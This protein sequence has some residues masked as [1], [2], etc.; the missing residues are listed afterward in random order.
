LDSLPAQLVQPAMRRSD[1]LVLRERHEPN[2]CFGFAR[3]PRRVD[4]REFYGGIIPSGFSHWV[5]NGESVEVGVYQS[6]DASQTLV[7]TFTS[8]GFEGHVR[9]HDWDRRGPL[10]WMRFR[11]RR[12]GPAT[13][14]ACDEAL[15][16]GSQLKR[17][18][19]R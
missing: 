8:D 5:Q 13:A 15:K 6:P 16:L 2:A 3:S 19:P 14:K 12:I 11:A 9:Q 10:V 18:G 4:G 17:S 7:G 1:R